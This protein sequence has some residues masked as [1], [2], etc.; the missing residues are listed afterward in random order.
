M[1][2]LMGEAFVLIPEQCA[3]RNENVLFN[4]HAKHAPVNANMP[5]I[6]SLNYRWVDCYF[7]DTDLCCD[8]NP[9]TIH[10]SEGDRINGSHDPIVLSKSGDAAILIAFG[11]NDWKCI[12]FNTPAPEKKKVEGKKQEVAVT[13][14]KKEVAQN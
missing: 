7:F 6:K 14:N 5:S 1:Q 9:I 10:P 12:L 2:K 11:V 4:C 13:E 8:K 3:M